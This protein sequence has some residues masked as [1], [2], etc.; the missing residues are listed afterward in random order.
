MDYF[1]LNDDGVA[2]LC[3]PEVWA[4]NYPN[5]QI[6]TCVNGVFVSTVFLGIDHS[7]LNDGPPV[8]FE[9]MTFTKRRQSF[10]KLDQRQW[11]YF[12]HKN[13]VAHHDA[14]VK[15]IKHK[16]FNAPELTL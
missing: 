6:K 14:I 4:S 3:T 16:R 15:A 2:E 10:K 13:A 7:F 9:T 11:R 5:W 12:D 8:L 1:K